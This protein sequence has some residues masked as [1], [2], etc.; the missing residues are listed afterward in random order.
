MSYVRIWVHCVWGTKRRE[1]LLT[2][3]V[4][5]ALF[6]HIRDNAKKKQ[7]Y[8]D[9]IDG[10]NKHVHCLFAL[11][12][13]MSVAKALQLIKGEASHW[14]NLEPLVKPRLEWADE[15]FASVGE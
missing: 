11:N 2:K 7:I 10:Y 9:T 5:Q 3:D 15:Y 13:D 4:R 12:A 6:S 8:V 14:S 1:P